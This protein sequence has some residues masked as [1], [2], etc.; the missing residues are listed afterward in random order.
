MSDGVT[1]VFCTLIETGATRWVAQGEDAVAFAPLLDG[2]LA[3]GHTLV[4]PREHCVGVLDASPAALQASTALVQRVSRAMTRALGATGVVV[5][6]ASGPHS[7][8]SVDHLHFHVVPCWPG[9]G[10]H[11]WPTDRSAH[12][13]VPDAHEQIAA[14]MTGTVPAWGACIV[15]PAT[16][17]DVPAIAALAQDMRLAHEK[18]Q[19]RFWRVAAGAREVHEPYLA[20]LVQDPAVIS[21]VAKSDGVLVG[22]LVATVVDAPPVYEPGGPTGLVDDFAVASEVLWD[23]AGRDLLA[24]ARVQLAG[25]GARQVVV[26]AGHHDE[27]KLRALLGAGLSRASEWLVADVAP[28]A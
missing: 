9:H 3:P 20:H 6:N 11:F 8:Q 15:G 10:A 28:G 13:P 16:A 18:V 7:G 27:A 17:A 24:E 12:P 23:S 14:A 25:R 2:M 19:P 4:V 26:V 1:C 5:L 21:L 22:Y